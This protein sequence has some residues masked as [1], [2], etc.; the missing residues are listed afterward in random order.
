MHG[1]GPIASTPFAAF[2]GP[3][4][5]VSLEEGWVMA[6]TL[7]GDY[8]PYLNETIIGSDVGAINTLLNDALA[9]GIVM[10]EGIVYVMHA[11]ANATGVADDDLTGFYIFAMALRDALVV[12]GLATS[13]HAATE[14]L[15]AGI[16]METLLQHGWSVEAVGTAEFNAALVNELQI[17]V[18]VIASM[19]AS[20]VAQGVCLV[21]MAVDENV[22]F[23]ETLSL[24]MLLNEALAEGIAAYVHIGLGADEY[25][26]WVLNTKLGAV[27]EYRNFPFNSFA[28]WQNRYFG[29]RDEG[30]YE[31]TGDTD[32]GEDIDAWVRTALE[33]FATNQFK[34]VPELY[35]GWR[36]DEKM[37]LKVITRDEKTDA[38]IEDH[39]LLNERPA[40]TM[41]PNRIKAGAMKSVY[42]AFE[43]HNTEGG[44]F[45]LDEIAFHPVILDRRL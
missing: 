6:E 24:S 41:G 33:T 17:A 3:S 44:D 38:I 2:G 15:V 16:A 12:S 45:S 34:R 19:T 36:S 9:E 20:G 8:A 37:L 23:D 43:L 10:D 22:V 39:Y 40:A 29:F 5:F 4:L 35:L 1:F 26:G 7:S 25:A 28:K 11:I 32:A 18:G 27:T 31:L 13:S 14:T 21:S 42:F 30:M